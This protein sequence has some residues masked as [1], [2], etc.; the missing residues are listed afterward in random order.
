MATPIERA[1]ALYDLSQKA[2]AYNMARAYVDGM[3]VLAMRD[4]VLEAVDRAR[5]QCAPMLIEARTY[6]FMGHSMSDPV[7][8]LYRSKEE[9][10]KEKQSDPI[11]LFAEHLKAEGMISDEYIAQA[12]KR[13]KKIVADCVE[14]A[15]NSP[16]PPP[17]ELW[18]HVY[19]DSSEA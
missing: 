13:I 8:G 3:D 2:C 19:K 12:E 14:F 16:E 1:S 7:H 17:E 9:V 10:E 11:L 15:E 6:R 4:T 5:S 18:N